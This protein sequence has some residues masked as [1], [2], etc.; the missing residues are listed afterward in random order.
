[1]FGGHQERNQ[2]AGTS[3]VAAAVGFGVACEVAIRDMGINNA[4]I[5]GLRDYMISQIETKIEGVKLNGHRSQRLP[6]N[7]NF[8]FSGVEG[9]AVL[10]RLDFAGI[11]V[12]TGSACTS[13]TLEKSHVLAAMGVS[14]ELNNGSVRFTLGR[15]TTKPDIDRT[16]S[17]L[18]KVIKDLRSISSIAAKKF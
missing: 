5:R 18:V 7:V 2:R 8:S 14:D 3:N 12:S 9:E 6:N 16:V 11:A 1:M 10:L 13:N 15:G 4:R 17:V